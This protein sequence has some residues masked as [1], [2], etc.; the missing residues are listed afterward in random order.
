MKVITILIIELLHLITTL[1]NNLIFA[2]ASTINNNCVWNNDETI[3][4][5]SNR[6]ETTF[7]NW[8]DCINQLRKD[9]RGKYNDFNEKYAYD[10]PKLNWIKS[11]FV[12]PQM[13]AHERYFYNGNYTPSKYMEDVLKRYGGIDS[14]LLWPTYPNIVADDRNQFEM[15][16]SMPGGVKGLREVVN[17]FHKF[18]VKVLLPYNPWD[19]GT[20]QP[21]DYPNNYTKQQIDANELAKLISEIDA[22]GFNGDT[23]AGV[24]KI[25]FDTGKSFGLSL[26][27]QPEGD[28]SYYNG[29]L[30]W[31]SKFLF[32]PRDILC[33]TT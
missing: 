2:S 5:P 25:Y 12:Q 19:K 33:L 13:M 31:V 27:I 16:R 9:A 24:A 30:T 7:N 6:D 4:P 14:V 22:D 18:G 10:D 21:S 11:N 3:P 8:F 26:A 15:I 17:E 32:P 28:V 1:T 23:M 20:L 29:N